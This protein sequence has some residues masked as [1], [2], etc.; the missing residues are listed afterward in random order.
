LEQ[1][2]QSKRR[3][4]V[5]LRRMFAVSLVTALGVVLAPDWAGVDP[6]EPLA[7]SFARPLAPRSAGRYEPAPLQVVPAEP[8]PM[9][10]AEPVQ[11][12][13]VE[14]FE[15]EPVESFEIEPVESFEIEPVEPVQL[16]PVEP[17]EQ[18]E[19]AA[20]EQSPYVEELM[21]DP[22]ASWAGPSP[23][24][25]PSGGTTSLDCLIEPYHLVDVGSS[26]TGLI[27]AI[28][29]ERA[30]RVEQGEVLVE[31]DAGVERAAVDL[32]RARA[33]MD[34][35][36][37]ALEAR[38]KLGTRKSER[39]RTLHSKQALSLDLREE[40]ET[41]AEVT[42]LE[43]ER[44]RDERR[45]ASLQLR[46]AE[47]VLAR[48]TIRSPIRGVVVARLMEPGERVED[49]TILRVAQ[50]DPLR[51]E[52]LLPSA[53]YGSVKPG[54]RA[55]ITPEIPGDEVYVAEVAIVDPL[56]DAASGTFGVRLE[57][58]NPDQAIPGGLHC[59]VRFL[60]E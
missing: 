12:E 43:F 10:Q 25:S 28:Q 17:V 31:L 60:D 59:Q 39:A 3:S 41:E 11:I 6:P 19:L 45:L 29:V 38:T 54:M 40:V 18:I 13:P 48:R 58:P 7:P 50:V 5:W 52:A 8:V 36:L 46:Q 35:D 30:D 22:E 27:E 42:R 47:E 53:L 4:G 56:I 26:V 37:K 33:R 23:E 2:N 21:L 49:E 34:S 9:V 20:I 51:V 57:L 14:S 32:A 15:I 16:E 24:S 44:A 55:A 1:V